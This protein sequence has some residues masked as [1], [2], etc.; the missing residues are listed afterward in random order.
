MEK[1]IE[2]V[3]KQKTIII[4]NIILIILAIITMSI[5]LKE[6]EEIEPKIEPKYFLLYQNEKMGVID[7]KGE[8][9]IKPI[10]ESIQIPNAQKPIFVCKEPE[11]TIVLNEKAEQILKKYIEIQAIEKQSSQAINP[12]Y[13]TV[14]IY[15]ENNQYGLIDLEGKVLTKPIYD[16]IKGFES[17]NELLVRQGENYGIITTKGKEKIKVQYTKISSDEYY[18]QE[19]QYNLSGYIVQIKTQDGYRLGYFDYRA[20]EILKPEYT[21]LYRLNEITDEKDIY[22]V[23]AQNGQYGLRK[24]KQQIIEHKYQ[25]IQYNADNELFIVKRN[26]KYGVL[27]KQAKTILP[28]EYNQI[29]FEGKFI[30]TTKEEKEEIYNTLGQIIEDVN[31]KS[32]Y[33]TNNKE[34]YISINENQKYGILD[35]KENKLVENQYTYLEYLYDNHFIASK[36]DNQFGVI[37]EKGEV[38]IEL[39]YDTLQL[40]KD[41]NIIQAKEISSDKV[42]LYN[43]TLQKISSIENPFIETND[44]YVK[45]YSN[46]D[47]IKYYDKQGQELKDTQIFKENNIFVFNENGKWGYKDKDG[48]I[49]VQAQYE[50]ATQINKYGYGGFKQDGKWGVI[51]EKGDII[52]Q[53]TYEILEEIEEIQFIAQY[54]RAYYQNGEYYYTDM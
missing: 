12:Y 1:I 3:K 20:R 5:F 16:E 44:G 8:I 2:K 42:D 22:L 4:I 32:I 52:L 10:Y 25:A 51:N 24:N 29:H 47:G 43:K 41:T 9:I 21:D 53:P 18:T 13:T 50:Y 34:Y 49:V 15:K 40:V 19:Q 6:N 7:T 38:V 33:L 31:Y 30:Y 35:K 27:D 14:L 36:E 11:R 46:K 37:N 28:I 45:I 54:R 48:Q 23:V 39:K 17:K 26:I